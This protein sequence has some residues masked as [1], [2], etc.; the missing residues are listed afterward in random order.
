MRY[1]VTKLFNND[2]KI[3]IDKIFNLWFHEL[4]NF[5]WGIKQCE[6]MQY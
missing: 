5:A 4:G 1:K 3:L 6:Q 2:S